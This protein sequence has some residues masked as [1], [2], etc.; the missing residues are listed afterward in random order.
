MKSQSICSIT[1]S[2]LI[3]IFSA[4]AHNVNV[5]PYAAFNRFAFIPRGGSADDD[6]DD[7]ISFSS[8]IASS[9]QQLIGVIDLRPSSESDSIILANY[10][11]IQQALFPIA[12]Q[13]DISV[14][15][16]E[17]N[18]QAASS[19]SIGDVCS[20]VYLIIT[21]DFENGKTVLHRNFGGIKLMAFVDGVRSRR[22]K[23]SQVHATKLIFIFVPSS[24]SA[25]DS[26][27]SDFP[28]S[29]YP[30]IS[31]SLP[32]DSKPIPNKIVLDL[33]RADEWDASGA[34]FLVDRLSEAFA[35][36]GEEYQN[37]ESFEVEMVGVFDAGQETDLS[38]NDSDDNEMCHLVLRH[39]QC[40]HQ[41]TDHSDTIRD[42]TRA[43]SDDFQDWITRSYESAGGVG[44]INFQ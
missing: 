17:M 40:S 16:D 27:L 36:G 4:H 23:L 20:T 32:N 2:I 44:D 19:H 34:N 26:L 42:E 21:Y 38:E 12:S 11:N 39:I 14:N 33:A 43:S 25:A 18:Q 24:S 29:A 5:N 1:S 9:Q 41:T 15:E 28:S 3:F 6:V 22:H 30:K 35:L 8:S 13:D 7:K 10:N 31:M 37:M